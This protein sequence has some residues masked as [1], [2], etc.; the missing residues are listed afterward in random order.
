MTLHD[1][2]FSPARP[3]RLKRHIAFWAVYST[4]YYFQSISPDCIKGLLPTDVF[5]YAFNS[6]YCFLP[7]CFFCVYVSLW[8]LFPIL[9]KKRYVAF[10]T[11]FL[12][13]L[14]CAVLM[15]Y[16]FSVLFLKVSSHSNTDH[17][18]FM[19]KFALGFLNSQNA[20]I[21]ACLALGIRLAGNWYLQKR[22][23]LVLQSRKTKIALGV[24]KMKI[25]PNYFFHSLTDI[26]DHIKDNVPDSAAMI[27]D[28]SD[29]LSYWLYDGDEERVSLEYELSILHK[30]IL[31]EKAR[32]GGN[33]P[34]EWYVD[35]ETHDKYIVP[36]ILFPFVQSAC[37]AACQETAG[38]ANII[39]RL[40]ISEQRLSL[41]IIMNSMG[42]G[43]NFD[44]SQREMIQS[45]IKKLKLYYPEDYQVDV[46]EGRDWQ[47]IFLSMP[48]ISDLVMQPSRGPMFYPPEHTTYEPA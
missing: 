4:Y 40:T 7:A 35:G 34:V 37:E 32:Q 14:C 9:Q 27:V 44:C 41:N 6:A 2:I 39:F 13:L 23:N 48:L 25:Q 5:R 18:I 30:F 22:E 19:R 33:L 16:F 38:N 24:M 20:M 45:S 36:M 43:N 8:I 3:H 26:Q 31:F 15:N 29:L 21:A 17:I 42:D 1:F 12:G 10:V 46:S 11:G 28:F 47:I